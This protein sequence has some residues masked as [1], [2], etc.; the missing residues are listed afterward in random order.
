MLIQRLLKVSPTIAATQPKIS[1]S[2]EPTRTISVM[3]FSYTL[4]VSG[5]YACA[6]HTI[7]NPLQCTHNPDFDLTSENWNDAKVDQLLY[8][9]WFNYPDDQCNLTTL[10]APGLKNLSPPN[11]SNNLVSG[12]FKQ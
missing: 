3:P 1:W 5:E 6:S 11:T 8:E 12:Y 2:V 7:L 4:S 9:W 10:G